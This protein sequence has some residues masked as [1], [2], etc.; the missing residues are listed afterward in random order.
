MCCNVCH[1]FSRF[2]RLFST[3]RR[4][5]SDAARCDPLESPATGVVHSV[6]AGDGGVLVFAVA[7]AAFGAIYG[8]V[9]GTMSSALLK[10]N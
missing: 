2:L 9:C 4:I 10:C 3:V 1:C 5:A 8:V 7:G 6:G